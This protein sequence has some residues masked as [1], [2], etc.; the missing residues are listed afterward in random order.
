MDLGPPDAPLDRDQGTF[1]ALAGRIIKMNEPMVASRQLANELKANQEEADDWEAL[2]AQ[3]P[4][5]IVA[6]R[7]AVARAAA[8][9][10]AAVAPPAVAPILPVAGNAAAV[11]PPAVAPILPVAPIAPVAAPA[12]TG[13][14]MPGN[15]SSSGLINTH[16]GPPPP[17]NPGQGAQP[18]VCPAAGCTN[19]YANIHSYR[20]HYNIIHFRK[21]WQCQ[22]CAWNQVQYRRSDVIAHFVKKN[23]EDAAAGRVRSH[24]Q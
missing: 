19:T 7:A 22:W 1:E 14:S 3:I 10:A 23:A 13:P 18:C 4:S 17:P 8:R 5:L 2:E 16:L 11:A 6:M 21:I 24:P 9:N 12:V 15:L 20:V